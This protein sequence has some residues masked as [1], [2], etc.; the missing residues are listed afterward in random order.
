MKKSVFCAVFLVLFSGCDPLFDGMFNGCSFIENNMTAMHL[1]CKRTAGMP[2][3]N[4]TTLIENGTLP[5]N[6][7]QLKISVCA[8]ERKPD[9]L[10]YSF[11]LS[12]GLHTLDISYNNHK[13]FVKHILEKSSCGHLNHLY[14]SHCQLNKIPKDLENR[15][16]NLVEIDFSFNKFRQIDSISFQHLKS[17]NL[18]SNKINSLDAK[19][20]RNLNTLEILDLTGI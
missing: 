4:C 11:I 20:F 1:F 15:I 14:A 7:K 3:D 5:S 18:S 19:T 17:L 2:Q 13:P 8:V 6:V 12:N 10:S 9:S 16:P